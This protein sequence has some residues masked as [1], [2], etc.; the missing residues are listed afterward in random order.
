MADRKISD[1]AALTTPAAGDYL[2]IVDISEI[3]AVSK[4]KRITVE[5]LLRGAP[6]GTAAAPSIAF[7]SDGG[8]GFY[9]AGTD[10]IGVST[11]GVNRLTLSTTAL[12]T[13]LPISYAL[14]A[15]AT[16]SITFTGDLNTGIYSPG[17]DQLSVAT[18]GT[19]RLR[20]DS[21]GQIEAVS[22]GTAAAPAYSWTGD[23][24]TG[25]YSPGA[26]QVA[27][28]TNGTGRLFVDS[29]GRLGLG[30][31]S[32]SNLLTLSETST[33]Q[34]TPTGS[35]VLPNGVIQYCINQDAT[36]DDT[37]C[38]TAWIARG[39][40]STTSNWYA[41]NTGGTSTIRSGA[42]V[43]GNRNGNTSYT[44]RLRIDSAGNVGLGTSSPGTILD[45]RQT[46]TGSET[47][48]SVFN[49]DNGNTTTQTAIIGLSPDSRAAAIAGI[50]AIK[51][52]ADFSTSA[53]RDVA[54][55]L[56]TTLN[57]AKRQAVYITSG[58]NVGIGTTSPD[59]YGV[60]A[61]RASDSV[62]FK[63]DS[64]SIS[65]LYGSATA[66]STGLL[67]TFTNH[68]LS[69][70]T[71]SSERARIDSSGRLLVGTSSARGSLR[72]QVEGTDANSSTIATTRNSADASPSIISLK[73]SRGTAAG[74]FTAVVNNDRVGLLAF[75]GA[76]GSADIQLAG[77]DAYVD[78]TPGANDM[79]GRLVLS[80]TLDGAS[81]PTEA[82]RITNDRVC[83]YNQAAPAAVDTTATLTVANLKT[84]I[85]TSST[86]A[87]VTMTLP[88]GTLTEG[89]FSG[90]Y[91]N[92]TFEW[93]VIN[94]GA[95]NAVTVQ[96][97]T[98]HTL[99][100]SG[101]VAAGVSG[102]F[103]SRRTAANTFVTYRLS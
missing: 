46:Q 87:A 22:L 92:M 76:D 61:S 8:N 60:H 31:S 18:G 4:N 28:S 50:E 9:L 102:R 65:T 14:G 17:A 51:E 66:L 2:P 1:L 3:A 63:A 48:V 39:S 42:F 47:K 37:A 67:G 72:F 26:N 77:I 32:P 98:D 34:Y 49:T 58:G 40:T 55:A 25:I 20:F 95:T 45:I 36:T 94:T 75:Y 24:D 74:S 90:V 41:G 78:G 91:T 29:S 6:D 70:Y 19:E 38:L 56:N 84:G 13:T 54:L 103:A 101:T 96:A 43:I 5:E 64:G 23:P 12:A 59:I 21:T 83:C 79:P 15:A 99:V 44:E 93:T 16:P 85:I 80:T 33:A 86:A 11:N 27:I 82:F 100:G 73:K 57:N 97:G 81:S 69:F 30:T 62:Y 88:T 71:N 7:E 89:G 35:A 53:A 52:N 68:P 10:T